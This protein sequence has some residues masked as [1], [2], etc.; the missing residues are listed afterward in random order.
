MTYLQT[1]VVAHEQYP[2]YYK[3]ILDSI[4]GIALMGVP[5]LGSSFARLRSFLAD[6]LQEFTLAMSTNKGLMKDLR[7]NSKPLMDLSKQADHRLSDLII[8]SFY[9]T[10]RL[11]GQVVSKVSSLACNLEYL[12]VFRL[13]PRI[14]LD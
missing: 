12:C 1:L 3:D 5:H 10:E 2:K 9:E 7:C 8:Y 11:D 13:L 6:V 14:R 4:K